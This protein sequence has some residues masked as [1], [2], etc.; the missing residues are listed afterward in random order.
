MTTPAY[1]LLLT[2]AIALAATLD[3]VWMKYLRPYLSNKY[4]LR[5]INQSECIPKV[6]W[7]GAWAFLVA[8]SGAYLVARHIA[9]G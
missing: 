6:A 1:L 4:R 2:T 3:S 8:V 5:P 7:V 9:A